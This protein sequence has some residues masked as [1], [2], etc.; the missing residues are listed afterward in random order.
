MKKLALTLALV[1]GLSAFMTSCASKAPETAPAPEAT[2]GAAAGDATASSKTKL[3]FGLHN[4]ADTLDYGITDNSFASWI[5]INTSEGLVTYDSGNNIVPAD[6]ESW[7]ISEDGL[8][9]TFKL[10][11][12]LKWSDGTPLNA[13]DYVYSWQRVLTPETGAHYVY[14]LTDY[15]KG[16]QDFYDGKIS[17]EE[18]GI[19]ALDDTTI[20]VTL[21]A[22]TP[23]Y[24][25][26]LSVWC[27]FPVQ[28]ATVEA[29]PETWAQKAETFISNGPF[30]IAAM[31][32][33]ESIVLAQNENYWDAGNVALEEITFRYIPESS[34]ALSAFET[35]ELDGFWLVPPSDLPRLKAESDALFPFPTFGTTYYMF[36]C[37][38]APFDNPLVRKA[39]SMAIDR[40]AII[41]N[42]LQSLDT[43]AYGMVSPGY[44]LPDG[45]DF[46]DGRSTFGL[47][48][49]AQAEEAK[50]LLAEAGYPNGEGFPEITLSYYTH[51]IMKNVTE[52]MQQMWKEN[53]GIDVKIASEEWKVYF[54]NVQAGN[55]DVCAMG[56]GGDYLHPMTFL[57]QLQTGSSSN[58]SFFSDPV[59]DEMVI[60]AQNELDEAKAAEIMK[61]AEEYLMDQMPIL[62]LYHRANVPMMN[63][64]LQGWYVTPMSMLHL[65][66]AYWAE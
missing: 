29:N 47:T 17:F 48:V 62:P 21:N 20:E 65:K 19:K 58:H 18:V 24:L 14:M 38:K 41:D 34:T 49:T 43:P 57:P 36:N 22:P 60:A 45:S 54:D 42:V 40:K 16:A 33:G 63:P 4:E 52:A 5:L 32:F 15:I 50:A 9:Y 53:L 51:P 12:D 27:Y 44:A 55:Y 66:D 56:W 35:G 23:Y 2:D 61:E 30:K 11:P 26:I 39:F 28:Q 46:T 3:I 13:N 1:F 25:G 37:G 59:Y 6:A 8:V 31:N 64:A 7:E 10:R